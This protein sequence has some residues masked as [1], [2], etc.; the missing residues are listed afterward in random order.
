[1]KQ[2]PGLASRLKPEWSPEEDFVA[3]A[4]L[5]ARLR[6]RPFEPFRMVTTDGTSYDVR[7]PDLV[8]VTLGSAIVGYPVSDPDPSVQGAAG[9]YDIV[10]LRHIIRLEQLPLAAP[11]L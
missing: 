2:G 1:V 5:L 3:P 4:D 10:S 7:H 11:P 6:T 8:L 9:R